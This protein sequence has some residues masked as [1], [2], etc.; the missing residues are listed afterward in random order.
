MSL[1]T[2]GWSMCFESHFAPYRA[3]GFQPARVV[4]ESHEI[5]TLALGESEIRGE[6]TGRLRFMADS[7]E[8]LPVTGDWVAARAFPGEDLSIIHAVLPRQTLL[9]RRAAGTEGERQPLAANVDAAWILGSMNRDFNPSRLERY[10]ALVTGCGIAP[11]VLLSKSDLVPEASA[12]AEILGQLPASVCPHLV[13]SKTGEGLDR[14]RRELAPGRTIALLGSSGAGKSTLINALAGAELR[15]T[16]E[17]R[18]ADQRGRH[19]T[20]SR[21]LVVL[22]GGGLILDSPGLREAGLASGL[23][24]ED[25]FGDISALGESCRFRDCRHEAE[26]GCSVRAAVEL[27]ELDARRLENFR[28]LRKEAEFFELREATSASFVE[29]SRWKAI[30]KMVKKL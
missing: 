28:K 29:K 27:G 18:D 24:A 20:T 3:E 25:G 23:T 26:P 12:R 4:T 11:L 1:Q 9:C 17:I 6:L 16:G 10:L 2:Y 30:H 15:L 14:L 21:D 22:P 8:E 19:T 5:Y 13:S 7:R